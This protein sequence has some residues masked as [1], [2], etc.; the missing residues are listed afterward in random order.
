[1]AHG[2]LRDGDAVVTSHGLIFYVVG[3]EHPEDRYHSILKYVPE[4]LAEELG[5]DWVDIRWEM[6]GTNLYRPRELYSPGA[7][8]SLIEAFRRSY[9]EYLLLSERLGR[10]LVTVPRR[11]IKEVYMPSRQLTKICRMGARD[12]FEERALELIGLLSQATGVPQGFF[13]VHGSISLGTS[14][15]GS[16][17]DLSIYG[18]SNFRRVKAALAELEE[19]GRLTLSRNNRVDAKRLNRGVFRGD[20]FVI[21]A[22]RRFSEIERRRRTYWPLGPVELECTCVSD[23]E[24]VFRPAIYKVSGCRPLGD[25]VLQL[26]GVS[27]MVS[28]IGR[29]RDLVRPGET[30]RARGVLEQVFEGDEAVHL[31]VFV[32]SALPGE[33]LDWVDP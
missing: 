12:R 20:R 17:V 5:L 13:G 32:G 15:E 28:M 23:E 7:Y 21:N 1:L 30:M 25:D 9:P 16:D 14:H 4:E 19:E 33:Y 2:N 6:G 18:T 10:L 31:R 8:G 3:Y 29:Q 11:L 24:A 27:E 26:Q 22:T